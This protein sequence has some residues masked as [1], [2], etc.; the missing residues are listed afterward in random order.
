[1]S[2]RRLG[3]KIML[4]LLSLQGLGS[5]AHLPPEEPDATRESRLLTEIGVTDLGDKLRI[6]LDGG[7]PL[8]YTI[9]TSVVPPSVTVDLPGLSKG[10]DLERMEVNHPP[11]LRVIPREISSPSAGV[12]LAFMLSV[13]VEP[14]VRTEGTRLVIDFPKGQGEQT[15]G[16]GEDGSPPIQEDAIEASAA[17]QGQLSVQELLT[18]SMEDLPA[19]TMSKVEVQRG[20]GEATVMIIGDGEFSYDIRL[21][22]RD[23]LIVDLLNVE[24][25]LRRRVLPVDHPLLKRIRIGRH[26]HM[27]RLVFDLPQPAEYLVQPGSNQLAVRLTP[28]AAPPARDRLVTRAE[29]PKI[30]RRDVR[31]DVRRP[32]P[33]RPVQ[34]VQSLPSESVPISERLALAGSSPAFA[35]MSPEVK[36]G[37]EPERIGQP[38]YSGRRISLDFQGADISNVFRLIAEVSGFNIVV[39]ETVKNKVT[40]KLVDVPWDQAL[41]M[42]LKMNHLGMIREGN[43]VWIDSLTNIARQQDE[44]AKAKESKIKAEDLVTRVIYVRNVSA[45]DLQVT[46]RQYLSPRGQLTVD[47][48]GN[49]LIIQ[50]T[51]SRVAAFQELV[52]VLDLE[53][54]Q[55]QIE[56]RIVQADTSYS[57]S[58]GVQWGAQ[59]G[60]TLDGNSKGVVV[61]N[62]TGPAFPFS[63]AGNTTGEFE[64]DFLVNLP[65]AV[66]GLSAVPGIGFTVGRLGS[67]KGLGLDLR[68]SAGELLGLTKV[69]AAPRITTLDNQ[70][71]KITQGESIPF[72]TTSL[73]GTQTTFVDANLTLEVTPQITSRDPKEVGRLILLKIKTTRNSVGARSNPAGPSIDKKEATTQVLVRDGDTMVIGG[74]FVDTQIN[75]VAG[76]PWFSRIPVLGWLFKTKTE[77]VA[78]QELLIFLTPTIVK[79]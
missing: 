37:R 70:L 68:L 56:A 77:S 61:G 23:R 30:Q 14:D 46:L 45:E 58:L 53:V 32:S 28:S 74:I 24:S 6:E 12:Q 36:A 63:A 18:Q 33:D 71:A 51:P 50:D 55:V 13:P 35:Q 54:P 15:V 16:A 47:R 72:Q 17:D 57:R 65:A 2:S 78:K 20:E 42:L 60:G 48:G 5:C 22:N 1:M 75:T 41:D 76:M 69:I 34:Y 64:S 7:S 67:A 8:S 10:A 31:R 62:L 29:P 39:G 79:T 21:L 25:L 9:S 43:I 59:V 66:S 40:V 38:R 3:V 4:V 73:Q 52:T 44:E 27:T 19:S 26:P 49:A 11:L